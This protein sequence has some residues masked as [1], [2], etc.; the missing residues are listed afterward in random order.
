M[1]DTFESA[2]DAIDR[3]QLA[4]GR[5]KVEELKAKIEAELCARIDARI[6]RRQ[7]LEKAAGE[8]MAEM[9]SKADE[10]IEFLRAS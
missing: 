6:E 10:L 9:L 4:I 8:A 2:V 1:F 7:V 3:E 5:A